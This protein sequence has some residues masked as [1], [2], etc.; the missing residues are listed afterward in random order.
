MAQDAGGPTSFPVNCSVLSASTSSVF[1][2]CRGSP[3]PVMT[4]LSGRA[5]RCS[6]ICPRSF[7]GRPPTSQRTQGLQACR[8]QDRLTTTRKR[9]ELLGHETLHVLWVARGRS[10]RVW[11][12][13]TLEQIMGSRLPAVRLQLTPHLIAL[14]ARG[15][16]CWPGR[17]RHEH[18]A[19][20]QRRLAG[21]SLFGGRM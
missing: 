5:K 1:V 3:R 2:S 4:F 12:I 20:T 8:R 15:W 9:C 19:R 14:M 21:T 6:K 16:L 18:F 11:R 7:R 17:L 10:A 13:T